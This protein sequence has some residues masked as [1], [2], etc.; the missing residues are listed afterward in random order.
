MK[1]FFTVLFYVFGGLVILFILYSM[2]TFP[3]YGG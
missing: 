3:P 1:K 2:F